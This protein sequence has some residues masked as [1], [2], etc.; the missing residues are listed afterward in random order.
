MTPDAQERA[1]SDGERAALW[2]CDIRDVKAHGDAVGWDDVLYLLARPMPRL[3]ESEDDLAEDLADESA[4][5]WSDWLLPV[6]QRIWWAWDGLH[7]TRWEIPDGFEEASNLDCLLRALAVTAYE[8][9]WIAR[10]RLADCKEAAQVSASP[11][12]RTLND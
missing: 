4:A 10:H 1:A 5:A 8:A 11:L 2:N 9:G 3:A 6:M 12:G 7:G